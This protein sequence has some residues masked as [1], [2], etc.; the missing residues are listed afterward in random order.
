MTQ[1]YYN[2]AVRALDMPARIRRLPVQRGYP[3]PW[4]VAPVADGYDFRVVDTPKIARAWVERRCWICGDRLG[5]TVCAV[6]G[7]MCAVNRISSEPPSHRECAEFAARACPFLVNPRMRRNEADMPEHW[8][9]SPGIP[10]EHNPG[11]MALWFTRHYRPFKVGG[12]SL[13]SYE[14]DP[15]EVAWWIEGR[16]ATR[17]EVVNALVAGLPRLRRVAEE[18][19]DRARTAL[20]RQIEKVKVLLP[21]PDEP[22]LALEAMQTELL[23]RH[24]PFSPSPLQPEREH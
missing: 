3:V 6:L 16:H 11:M 18:E 19:G 1:H 24:L 4:F 13:F 22:P 7:P 5:R 12:G 14:D 23:Q 15:V 20:A 2:A 21:G 8:L 9:P 17:E 10:L